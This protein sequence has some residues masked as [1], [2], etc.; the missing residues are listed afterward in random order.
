MIT[1]K[2]AHQS[3][4]TAL[5]LAATI[6]AYARAD[7]TEVGRDTDL[8]QRLEQSLHDL[9]HEFCYHSRK[10]IERNA[11]GKALPSFLA[12]I[13]VH[14]KPSAA[15]LASNDLV[16]RVPLSSES[17]W[18]IV[19]R[20]VHSLDFAVLSNVKSIETVGDSVI[21][22]NL[23]VGSLRLVSFRSDRDADDTLHYVDLEA[24]VMTFAR[25]IVPLLVP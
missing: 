25:D 7:L 19:N 16:V 2:I 3:R 1:L 17:F 21:W 13:R 5:N 4:E 14:P 23:D 9:V 10:A 24:L 12:D 18:W 15:L 8:Q 22:S 6:V 11:G 20:I